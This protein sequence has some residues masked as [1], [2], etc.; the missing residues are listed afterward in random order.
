MTRDFEINFTNTN[1][2]DLIIDVLKNAYIKINNEN[3][4][5]AFSNIDITSRT[6]I[7]SSFVYSGISDDVAIVYEDR[8]ISLKNNIDFIALKNGGHIQKGWAITNKDINI[9]SEPVPIW[10]LSKQVL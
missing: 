4:G 10:E 5:N 3:C 7:F 6:S 8:E 2:F 1:Y 9:E